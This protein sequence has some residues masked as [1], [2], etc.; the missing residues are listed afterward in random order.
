[1]LDFDHLL[2]KHVISR[3]CYHRYHFVSLFGFMVVSS[4]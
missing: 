1:M 4:K 2:G 3:M